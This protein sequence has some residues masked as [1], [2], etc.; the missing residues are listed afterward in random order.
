MRILFLRILIA[1][2]S[3]IEVKNEKDNILMKVE[4]IS[5]IAEEISSSAEEITASI[6]EMTNLSTK[7]ANTSIVL[8]DTTKNM[9]L[10]EEKF[11]IE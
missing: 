3:I 8:N 2:T 5:A 9:I 1:N 7:V 6:K 11:K 4:S 10:Q